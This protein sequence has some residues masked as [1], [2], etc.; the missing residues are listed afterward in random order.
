MK[1]RQNEHGSVNGWMIATIGLIVLFLAA[2]AFGVWVYLNYQD[3]KTDVDSRVASAVAA[4]KKVQADSDEA[5]FIE[6]DKQPNRQFVGPDDYGRLTFD[7]PKTWSAYVAKDTSTGGNFEAYLNPVSVPPI[8]SATRVALRVTIEN[9]DFDTVLKNYESLVKH[10]DLKSSAVMADGTNGT[11]LD[12]N[13]T[14]D[15]RGSAVIYKIRDKTVTIRTDADTF[16][17][18]FENL[19]KTIKFNQ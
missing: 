4:A 2:V 15:I 13:F 7:Y 10:G 6:R 11:R 16:K 5:K 14:K 9:R 3:Q 1:S 18:D 17:P 8:S 12:G 19:I